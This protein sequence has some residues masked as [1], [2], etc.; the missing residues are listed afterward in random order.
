MDYYA[1]KRELMNAAQADDGKIKVVMAGPADSEG[2]G[3]YEEE[4]TSDMPSNG[5]EPSPGMMH[6][7][8]C[9]YSYEMMPDGGVRVAKLPNGKPG[10]EVVSKGD[11]LY[12]L[13]MHDIKMAKKPM[14]MGHGPSD[15]LSR[16]KML[17]LM[18]GDD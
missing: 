11:E 7:G 12:G 10:S 17:I 13:V 18:G 8:A 1:K 15:E 3:D 16:A 2:E 4:D 5:G 9:G 6:K 14:M